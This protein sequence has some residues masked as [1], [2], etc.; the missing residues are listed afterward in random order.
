MGAPDSPRKQHIVISLPGA[1]DQI[2]PHI[3]SDVE[4]EESLLS[5][6]TPSQVQVVAAKMSQIRRDYSDAALHQIIQLFAVIN[7][8]VTKEEAQ[9]ISRY[10]EENHLNIDSKIKHGGIFFL[11]EMRDRMRPHSRIRN[12]THNHNRSN[13]DRD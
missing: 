4:S 11:E 3:P 13:V 1:M 6:L 10:C 9:F 7:E 2:P 5:G 12:R 8:V